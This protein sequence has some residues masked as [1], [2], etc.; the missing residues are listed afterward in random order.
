MFVDRQKL[1]MGKAEI[2][3][4]T[5]KL[6]GEIAIGQPLIVALA[7]PRAEMDFIDRHRRAQRVDIGGGGT[8]MRQLGLIEND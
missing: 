2:P 5:G 8:W 3:D 1:H 4:I 7:A 6:L